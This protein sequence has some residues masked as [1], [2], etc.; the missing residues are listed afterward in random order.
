M[1]S[2]RFD[3][4]AWINDRDRYESDVE[5]WTGDVVDRPASLGSM[6]GERQRFMSEGVE[7]LEPKLC[8]LAVYG[9][10]QPEHPRATHIGGAVW[11]PMNTKWPKDRNGD[12]ALFLGQVY[13][14][15]SGDVLNHKL[16]GVALQIFSTLGP[17]GWGEY[18]DNEDRLLIWRSKS[19]LLRG[20]WMRH[21]KGC[22]PSA[23]LTCFMYRTCD[24]QRVVSKNPEI[25]DMAL[26]VSELD[27]TKIGGIAHWI[28][29]T[30]EDY[31]VGDTFVCS[32]GSMFYI[33][34]G[35]KDVFVNEPDLEIAKLRE[36]GGE[37]C[38][39]DMGLINVMRRPNGRF[40][41]TF[42]CS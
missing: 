2:Y 37:P 31:G 1:N 15:D 24:F 13:F 10:G 38:W 39:G 28:Q 18:W 35:T 11:M 30:H 14:G 12:P 23:P 17:E 21:P 33:S 19:E 4:D 34:D 16:P 6:L 29:S 27:G 36:A 7:F 41:S 20:D 8:D 9:F 42:E 26:C 40:Y 5:R 32:L 22:S 25:K 3:L